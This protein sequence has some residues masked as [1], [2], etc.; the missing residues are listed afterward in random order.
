MTDRCWVGILIDVVERFDG[1]VIAHPSE[2]ARDGQEVAADWLRLG[3]PATGPELVR[4]LTGHAAE[5]ADV[6]LLVHHTPAAPGQPEWLAVTD[7]SAPPRIH[8]RPTATPPLVD[9]AETVLR[10]LASTGPR[11][12]TVAELRDAGSAFFAALNRRGRR[13]LGRP[14][15]PGLASTL[16]NVPPLLVE[17]LGR[18]GLVVELTEDA[19]T[20]Q[21]DEEAA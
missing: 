13:S 21:L 15:R 7:L 11:S 1:A 4:L 9:K 2:L 16:A 14:Q 19:V 8:P 5:L 20:V 17:E 10:K 12:G 18:R 6:G 3:W